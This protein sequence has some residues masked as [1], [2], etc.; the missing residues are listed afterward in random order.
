MGND[1]RN[2]FKQMFMDSKIQPRELSTIP[3]T[4]GMPEGTYYTEEQLRH[5]YDKF[6]RYSRDM[7]E[8]WN[9]YYGAPQYIFS[10]PRWLINRDEYANELGTSGSLRDVVPNIKGLSTYTVRRKIQPY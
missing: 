1:L 5:L 7:E 10:A 4:M 3:A 9:S 6:G 2:Y 8:P